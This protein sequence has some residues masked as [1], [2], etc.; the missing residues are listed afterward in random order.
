MKE[1]DLTKD[2]YIEYKNH[3]GE[4][5]KAERAHKVHIAA[6]R[7]QIVEANESFKEK[8]VAR[9]AEVSENL[10]RNALAALAA[11]TTPNALLAALGSRNVTWIYNLKNS[12][13][14]PD[15]P[16]AD[17][18]HPLLVDVS[19]DYS[20]HTGTHGVL[21][22]ADKTLFKFYSLTEPDVWFIVDNSLELVT[23]SSALFESQ[24]KPEIERRADLLA[25]ILDGHY[26]G[27]L[28]LQHN[29]FSN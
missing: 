5:A 4:K 11:G 23:G 18:V 28:R 2:A 19:W 21:R 9:K 26:T 24:T 27:Q 8:W 13:I 16:V 3:A 29:R 22:S 15:A 14:A 25:S 7:A 1:L 20:E 12:G 17:T 10:D 6:L